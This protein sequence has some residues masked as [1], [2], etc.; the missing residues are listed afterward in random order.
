MSYQHEDDEYLARLGPEIWRAIPLRGQEDI[1]EAVGWID[2]VVNHIVTSQLGRSDPFAHAWVT[3][4]LRAMLAL[5]QAP[6]WFRA[7]ALEDA[8]NEFGE[9]LLGEWLALVAQ[10]SHYGPGHLIAW[11]WLLNRPLTEPLVDGFMRQV[12][13]ILSEVV[14]SNKRSSEAEWREGMTDWASFFRGGN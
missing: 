9:R 11:I 14:A 1:A 4:R 8:R 12:T 10:P 13:P 7:W 3:D 2:R 5:I 6:Q